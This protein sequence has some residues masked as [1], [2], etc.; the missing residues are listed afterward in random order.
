PVVSKRDCLVGA[1]PSIPRV[2]PHPSAVPLWAFDLWSRIDES[3][4]GSADRRT[5]PLR[6][7]MGGLDRHYNTPVVQA[8]RRKATVAVA[9]RSQPPVE[10]PRR[11]G[12][13]Y[14]RKDSV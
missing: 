2:V 1:S 13:L 9:L 4:P 5:G 10:R 3:L 8:D 14:A 12:R 6:R 7:S 11:A